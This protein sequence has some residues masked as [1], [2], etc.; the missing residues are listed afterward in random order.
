MSKHKTAYKAAIIEALHLHALGSWSSLKYLGVQYEKIDN[1]LSAVLL[2]ALCVSPIEQTECGRSSLIALA[3]LEERSACALALNKALMALAQEHL[4]MGESE[5]ARSIL[6]QAIA[7]TINAVALTGLSLSNYLTDQ[8]LGQADQLKE[9]LT[10]Q[11]ELK[12]ARRYQELPAQIVLVLGMNCSGTSALTSLLV[13]AGLEVPLDRIPATP[14]NPSSYWESVDEMRINNELL[15]KLGN[16]WSTCLGL[17]LHLCDMHADAISTWRTSLLQMLQTVFPSGK[18]AVLKDPQLCILLPALRPWLESSIITYAVFLLIHHPAEVITSL[19][20]AE[21]ISHRQALLKWLGHVFHSE[22]NSRQLP[23][24]I[25]N[26][27]E[28]LADPRKVLTCSAEIM[29][30]AGDELVLPSTWKEEEAINLSN[31]T[32]HRQREEVER[33][34]W[35]HK[36][37][38][39]AWYDLALNIYTVMSSPMLKEKKR[40]AIMDQLWYQWMAMAPP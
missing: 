38:A 13:Q 12:I 33:P 22:R 11:L 14:Q 23:R 39:K 17:P 19:C 27:R 34:E 30:M 21:E 15:K 16:H 35:V 31:C 28:L 7:C 32:L 36:E 9:T 10:S 5:N 2:R 4:L 37:Q 1:S 26:Y 8:L 20:D 24:L 25:I 40:R 29:R 6:R 3:Q 18:R